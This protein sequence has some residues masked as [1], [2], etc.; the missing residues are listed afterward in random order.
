MAASDASSVSESK[1]EELAVLFGDGK[2]EGGPLCF[3]LSCILST[4]TL[5]LVTSRLKLLSEIVHY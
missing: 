5:K 2:E 3:K 4:V 1:M